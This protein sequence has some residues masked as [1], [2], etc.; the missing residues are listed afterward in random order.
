MVTNTVFIPLLN[1]A[2]DPDQINPKK[3]GKQKVLGQK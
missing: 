2:I 3:S 1:L